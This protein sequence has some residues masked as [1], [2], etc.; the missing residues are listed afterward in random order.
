MWQC[1]GIES[2]VKMTRLRPPACATG[3]PRTVMNSECR[4]LGC[5]G[6]TLP[7]CRGFCVP[8]QSATEVISGHM[9]AQLRTAP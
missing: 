7:L 3:D 1:S 2:C 8:I 5:A 4:V 9:A 6:L